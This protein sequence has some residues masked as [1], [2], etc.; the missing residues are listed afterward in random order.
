M[1]PRKKKSSTYFSFQD[2]NLIYAVEDL[3]KVAKNLPIE[4]IPLVDIRISTIGGGGYTKHIKRVQ[5]ADLSYPIIILEDN[6]VADGMHRVIKA[7]MRG[8]ETI[9]AVRIIKMP[10]PREILED[11]DE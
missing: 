5:K 4:E 6:W 8:E 9:K 2:G 3:W 7:L 11:E 10:K 1:S